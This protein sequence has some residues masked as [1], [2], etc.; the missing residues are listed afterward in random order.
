MPIQSAQATLTSEFKIVPITGFLLFEQG[1]L[2]TQSGTIKAR[3]RSRWSALTTWSSFNNYITEYEQIK[4]T[5]PMIDIG[6]KDYFNLNITTEFTGTG[7]YYLVHVSDTGVFG[8]EEDE[9]LLQEGNFNITAFYGRYVYVTV[10]FTGTELIRFTVETNTNK[11]IIKLVNINTSTLGGSVS[12]RTITMPRSVSTIYDMN[13]ECKAA[14]SY[15]VNL[16][17]SDTATS[18]VLIPV[19]KS[20]S[21][22][23]PAIALYGI[24]NDPR[25]GVVDITI[26]ALP[27]MVMTG[28]NVIVIE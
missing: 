15:A 7:L 25:D 4:W 5:A 28:G 6:S 10:I 17:V 9:F 19:V 23:A 22:T 16:Y 14:T 12:N 18:E 26:T 13:I 1:Q 24:D 3:G 8:G 2:D 27:R 20:K 21:A 11:S